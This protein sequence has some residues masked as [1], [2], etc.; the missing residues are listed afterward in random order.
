LGRVLASRYGEIVSDQL[1]AGRTLLV[2]AFIP[3]LETAEQALKLDATKRAR[4]IVRL[5]SG[6]G[7]I[8]DI[9]RLLERGYQV[10]PKDYSR[11][12]PQVE[13]GCDGVG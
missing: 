5:D 10:Q 11:A 7:S 8:A 1:F 13:L 6:G 12:R 2:K 3:L 4:T 9:N